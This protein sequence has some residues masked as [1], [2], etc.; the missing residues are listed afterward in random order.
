M[1]GEFI[2]EYDITGI[3]PASYNPRKITD[4]SLKILQ[5]SIKLLGIV[6]PIIIRGDT[7]IAGHQRTKA[8]V[9]EGGKVAPAYLLAENVNTYDEMLFNQLHNGTDMDTG[10]EDA[11]VE[12]LVRQ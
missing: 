9:A 2:L 3:K 10:D 6:K 5:D 11:V 1:H 7:I 12:R 8:L 4:E